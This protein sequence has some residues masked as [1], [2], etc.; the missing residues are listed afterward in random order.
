M[1]EVDEAARV[2]TNACDQDANIIFGAT[3]DP[4]FEEGEIKITV[5]AT[6]FDESQVTIRHDNTSPR[7]ANSSSFGR[8]VLGAQQQPS[9][10]HSPSNETQGQDDLD[11]PAFLRNKGK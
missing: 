5:I 11:I 4:D 8:R 9:V 10:P 2:I 6:G 3:I 1:F 7:P